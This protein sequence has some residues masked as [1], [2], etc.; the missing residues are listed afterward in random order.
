MHADSPETINHKSASFEHRGRLLALDLGTKRV[1]VAISDELQMT[2]SP[3]PL[4][5]RRSW[6][7]LLAQ[8]ATTIE[9][10]D[11]QGLVVGLPL[12]MDGTEGVAAAEVKRLVENFRRSLSVPIYLQD[13]RLTSLAAIDELKSRGHKTAD[14]DSQIDSESAAIILRD[15]LGRQQQSEDY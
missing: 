4:I 11:A 5:I 10:Y 6:K 15:F 14:I 9:A 13:E 1:G 12:N 7:D 3:L 8:I 2:T